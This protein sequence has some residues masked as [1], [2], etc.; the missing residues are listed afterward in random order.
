FLHSSGQWRYHITRVF[1]RH[2]FYQHYPALLVCDWIVPHAFRNDVEIARPELDVTVLEL[3]L[4]PTLDDEEHLI[5]VIVFVPRE[6]TLELRD[7]DIL[8]V[9]AADHSG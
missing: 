5:L 8:I 7:L 6:L 1:G 9:H 3:D 2:R 4:Q